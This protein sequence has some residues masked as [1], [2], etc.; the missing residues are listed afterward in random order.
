MARKTPVVLI[1]GLLCNQDLWAHQLATLDDIA[2]MQVADTTR[3]DNVEDM[4]DRLLNTAPD[5]FALAGLSMGGYVAQEVMRI[6]PQRVTRLA[7]IDTSAR[8]DSDEQRGRRSDLIEQVKSSPASKFSGVTK[9]LLPMLIHS[10][11]L[12]DGPLT[13]AIKAMAKD[14]GRDTYI[15]QQTAILNRPDGLDDLEKITCPTTIICGREDTLTPLKVHE[16]MK[17]RIPHATLVIIE[18]CGHL[19]AMERPYALSALLRYWLEAPAQ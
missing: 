2:Q 5:T 4:V 6:A 17:S 3:D 8:A 13:D 10:D 18:E 14:L 1:P 15:R 16:E 12:D 9:R 11:R 7:L 19:P